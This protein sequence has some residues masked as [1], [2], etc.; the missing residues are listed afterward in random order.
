[1]TRTLFL[2]QPPYPTAVRWNGGP[3]GSGDTGPRECCLQQE[4]EECRALLAIKATI[5]YHSKTNAIIVRELIDLMGERWNEEGWWAVSTDRHLMQAWTYCGLVHAE[6][7]ALTLG[8]MSP[9]GE[10]LAISGGHLAAIFNLD[11]YRG[12]R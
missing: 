2:G 8:R 4:T 11:A 1:M 9:S 10:F 6:R 3:G 5:L 7:G 12:E